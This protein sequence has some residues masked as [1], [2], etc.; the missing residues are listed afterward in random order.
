MHRDEMKKNLHD[1]FDMNMQESLGSYRKAK[2]KFHLNSYLAFENEVKIQSPSP[3][4]I[5]K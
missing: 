3:H 1:D 4:L 5:R 2:G